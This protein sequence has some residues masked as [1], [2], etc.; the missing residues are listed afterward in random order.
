MN[1]LHKNIYNRIKK[2]EF[3]MSR[4]CVSESNGMDRQMKC[5]R[6]SMREE[7]SDTVAIEPFME[8]NSKTIKMARARVA[9]ATMTK[10]KLICV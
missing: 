6:K 10:N 3:D 7:D 9:R 5:E 2:Y 1:H 8:N 4:M